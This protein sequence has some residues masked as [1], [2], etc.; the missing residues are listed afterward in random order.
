MAALA[1]TNPLLN[2]MNTNCAVI[3]LSTPR[4]LNRFDYRDR[5]GLAGLS[6][7]SCRE[8]SAKGRQHRRGEP[9]PNHDGHD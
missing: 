7:P 9:F 5:V 3:N 4:F 1:E 8:R 6:T 2:S